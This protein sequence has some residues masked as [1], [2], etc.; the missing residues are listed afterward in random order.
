MSSGSSKEPGGNPASTM[1]GL[2][3]RTSIHPSL[4][5]EGGCSCSQLVSGC[6]EIMHCGRS[7]GLAKGISDVSYI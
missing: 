4:R 7:R 2:G 5:K 3:L 1:D 6:S